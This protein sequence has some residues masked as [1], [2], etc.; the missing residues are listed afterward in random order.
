MWQ[1][2]L[3]SCLVLRDTKR[4]NSSFGRDCATTLRD[5]FFPQ[6]VSL[7]L[8]IH[9]Y[10][11]ISFKF[12]F[13]E[14]MK[15]IISRITGSWVKF[16]KPKVG[17]LLWLRKTHCYVG[18]SPTKFDPRANSWLVWA[19]LQ[20]Q[21]KRCLTLEKTWMHCVVRGQYLY[22][23]DSEDSVIIRF[24]QCLSAKHKDLFKSNNHKNPRYLLYLKQFKF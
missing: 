18:N 23:I 6:Q 21:Q 2:T 14:C 3:F 8:S 12:L 13:T 4:G 20:G 11:L 17:F 15:W 19:G 5:S 10:R 7:Q 22:Q 1:G 24:E 16:T 9:L